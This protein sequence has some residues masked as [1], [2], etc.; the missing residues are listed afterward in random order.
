MTLPPESELKHHICKADKLQQLFDQNGFEEK[1][2]KCRQ[3][4]VPITQDVWHESL[5]C[6]KEIIQFLDPETGDEVA[7]VIE[8][9]YVDKQKGQRRIIRRIRVGIDIYD[10]RLQ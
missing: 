9:V 1:L 3:V 7:C 6:K 2:S 10:L 8:Q 4:R 5:C